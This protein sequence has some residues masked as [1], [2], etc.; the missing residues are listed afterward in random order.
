MAQNLIPAEYIKFLLYIFGTLVMLIGLV[1]LFI[2]FVT[3]LRI[4]DTGGI[5]ALIFGAI[6]LIGTT[7]VYHRLY[8]KETQRLQLLRRHYMGRPKAELLN[9][10]HNII[11]TAQAAILDIEIATNLCQE[12]IGE[13]L[14]AD[15]CMDKIKGA[16]K[17]LDEADVNLIKLKKH[18]EEYRNY[19]LANK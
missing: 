17:R 12:L 14:N 16:K 7:V 18:V 10:N 3:D 19:I 4:T 2:D 9:I 13:T 6:I 1:A 5:I 11:D 8:V 15:E